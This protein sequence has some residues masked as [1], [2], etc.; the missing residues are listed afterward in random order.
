MAKLEVNQEG[1]ARACERAR[2]TTN[3]SVARHM[4]IDPAT[5]SRVLSGKASPGAK[6]VTGALRTFGFAWFEEIFSH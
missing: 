6:F 1:W 5:L 4:G 2:L 3:S